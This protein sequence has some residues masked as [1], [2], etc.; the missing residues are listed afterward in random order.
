LKVDLR[1]SASRPFLFNAMSPPW[2]PDEVT[3]VSGGI[4]GIVNASLGI[5]EIEL[6]VENFRAQ[7][8]LSMCRG[9]EKCSTN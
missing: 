4:I 7:V 3:F 1:E 2:L 5:V 8:G 9:N 6:D